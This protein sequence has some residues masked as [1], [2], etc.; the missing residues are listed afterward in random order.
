MADP[1]KS[2]VAIVTG[3]GSGIG[4]AVQARN[5][6]RQPLGLP[7]LTDADLV[8]AN[9]DGK[10]YLPNSITHAWIKLTRRCGLPGRRLHDCRHSYATSLLKKNVHPSVVASQLG[11]AS[12]KTTL[13]I[14]SHSVP[15][16]QEPAATKFD[17]IVIGNSSL[18]ESAR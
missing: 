16:L 1:L 7:L 6:I 13:D 18:A 11:H 14:Y 3:A 17:D 9:Y 15:Q 2:K 5:K 8:F 12:V 10:P 4:R